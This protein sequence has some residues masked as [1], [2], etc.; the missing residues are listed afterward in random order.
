LEKTISNVYTMQAPSSKRIKSVVMVLNEDTKKPLSK[1]N[2]DPHHY[3]SKFSGPVQYNE[4]LNCINLQNSITF[5]WDKFHS[6][7]GIVPKPGLAVDTYKVS[8]I[9]HEISVA[10]RTAEEAFDEIYNLKKSIRELE[11]IFFIFNFNF[12]LR[13]LIIFYY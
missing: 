9:A 10:K 11:G 6:E 8:A 1:I 7:N 2:D 4:D 12:L 5:D 3:K 13:Y